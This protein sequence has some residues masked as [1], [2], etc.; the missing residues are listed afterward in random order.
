MQKSIK[1]SSYALLAALLFGASTPAAK[2][3]LNEI[4]PQ[5]LAGILYLGSGLGLACLFIG[6]T[7]VLKASQ[8]EASI[9]GNELPWLIGA[10]VTGGIIAPV[11]LMVGLSITPASSASL[12]LN[13]EGVFTALLAWFIFKENFDRRIVLGM[14]LI[15]LGGGI[16]SWQGQAFLGHYSGGFLIAA[17]CFLWA[18]DNN[19][20]RKISA[21]DPLQIAMFK[22]LAAGFVNVTLFS[23]IT[24]IKISFPSFAIGCLIGFFGYGLSLTLFIMSLRKLGTARTTAYFS[25][26]PFI[27]AILSIIFLHDHLTNGFWVAGICMVIGVWLHLTERH[28]HMH[29]HEVMTHEHMH[30]HD[31]HHQHDHDPSI[32]PGEPHSH[33]HTHEPIT[34]S[35]PH[36]PDIHHRHTHDDE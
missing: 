36:Y 29:T 10:I 22:G 11:L 21:A 1:A 25:T 8:R 28:E 3:I 12:I 7:I 20:T 9:K 17:A 23:M 34:H 5:L 30:V 18:I 2:V 33:V 31:E 16:L 32:P 26:A 19:L 24:P 13:L 15:L 35:H 14:I 27:G 4:P 6:R